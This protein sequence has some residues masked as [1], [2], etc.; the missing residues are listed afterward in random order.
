MPE[1]NRIAEEDVE[2]NRTT[3]EEGFVPVEDAVEQAVEDS[4]LDTDALQDALDEFR[5]SER[6]PDYRSQQD[7]EIEDDF[8]EEMQDLADNLVVV[9]TY[10]TL[11]E[12]NLHDDEVKISIN[13]E[14]LE[15]GSIESFTLQYDD[16]HLSTSTNFMFMVG[17]DTVTL[18][19]DLVLEW[20]ERERESGMESDTE[21]M[22]DVVR[23]TP[24]PASADQ[25]VSEEVTFE[26][27][28][29]DDPVYSST[30][31]NEQESEESVEPEYAD[32]DEEREY[33]LE[34]TRSDE[35]AEDTAHELTSE[36]EML[37][38]DRNVYNVSN[39]SDERRLRTMAGDIET[40]V[41]HLLS[42][43]QRIVEKLERMQ[44]GEE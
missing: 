17:E 2:E 31:N 20:L 26:R 23:E 1:E 40:R 39:I 9:E 18:D 27:E 11:S 25:E 14:L 37:E 43:R 38:R 22:E 36:T 7:W 15:S 28:S 41:D 33:D 10:A 32:I 35:M 30:V 42:K 13:T 5:E 4:S 21:E 3:E 24:E 6:S 44:E 16:E 8:L 34:A 19:L 12:I 29:L